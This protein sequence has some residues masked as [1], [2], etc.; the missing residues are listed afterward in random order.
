MTISLKKVKEEILKLLR[1]Q[2]GLKTNY[3]EFDEFYFNWLADKIIEII[4]KEDN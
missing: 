4:E 2:N 1:S 3:T